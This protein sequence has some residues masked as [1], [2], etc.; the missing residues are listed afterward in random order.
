MSVLKKTALIKQ[1]NTGSYIKGKWVKD[2][3]ND[4]TF[5]GTAQ[6]ASGKAMELLK[7]GKRSSEAIQVFAPIEMDFTPAD[8]EK[9]V[10][11]DIIVWEGR[12]YEVQ[13]ARKWKV[14]LETDHWELVATR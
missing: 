2:P 9:Q 13:V 10:S 11:G 7:E 3:G 6:P 12:C 5:L 8:S 1:A 14:G 4:V